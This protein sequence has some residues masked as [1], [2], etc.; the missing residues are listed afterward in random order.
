MIVNEETIR[1]LTRLELGFARDR[2]RSVLLCFSDAPASPSQPSDA[3][4]HNIG[5]AK[6]RYARVYTSMRHGDC[7]GDIGRSAAARRPNSLSARLGPAPL[8]SS[9]PSLLHLCCRVLLHGAV[10]QRGV[11]AQRVRTAI[12]CVY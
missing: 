1:R 3:V 8:H 7:R 5:S 12:I 9:R 11:D 2:L 10:A 6:A 4:R